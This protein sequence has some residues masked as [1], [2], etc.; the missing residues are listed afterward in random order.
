[1]PRNVCPSCRSTEAPLSLRLPPSAAHAQQALKAI[2]A[3][4][5]LSGSTK[6]PVVVVRCGEL[7]A[8]PDSKRGEST[9]TREH[10]C[11]HA[12]PSRLFH[13]AT[14]RLVSMIGQFVA[15][16]LSIHQTVSLLSDLGPQ[17][18]GTAGSGC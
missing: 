3:A 11:A 13:H 4:G 8:V 2:E 18:R 10:R 14:Y 1:M 15:N 16:D 6:E 9:E 12:S 17:A 5:T 7:I